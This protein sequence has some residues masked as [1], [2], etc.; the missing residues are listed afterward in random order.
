VGKLL[1]EEPTLGRAITMK[2]FIFVDGVNVRKL[3]DDRGYL[4]L[5]NVSKIAIPIHDICNAVE[6]SNYS[7]VYSCLK[8]G[9]KNGC[10]CENYVGTTCIRCIST[11]CPYSDNFISVKYL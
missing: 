11:I 6:L 1:R 7:F 8:F 5:L 10:D 4:I 9:E 3:I 2:E